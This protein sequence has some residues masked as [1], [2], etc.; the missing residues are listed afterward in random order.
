MDMPL[1]T[2]R[3]SLSHLMAHA[4]MELYPDAQFAIGPAIDTGWYYD[5]DFISEKPTEA[6]FG[7]IEKRKHSCRYLH[8][9]L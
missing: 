8:G 7:K 9:Q 1:S 3:H 2:K 5:I 6:D 4:I